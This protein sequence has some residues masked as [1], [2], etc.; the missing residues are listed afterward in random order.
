MILF[1]PVQNK[2]F[3]SLYHL[4]PLLAMSFHSTLSVTL[5]CLLLSY[6]SSFQV[7]VSITLLDCKFDPR[8][9][10]HAYTTLHCSALHYTTWMPPAYSILL[11][12]P[13]GFISRSCDI[14][15]QATSIPILGSLPMFF[16]FDAVQRGSRHLHLRVLDG[17]CYG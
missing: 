13:N 10:F 5:H 2:L 3:F 1:F 16:P 17:A 6:I 12:I 8:L 11:S 4:F 14:C 7:L 15:I 9:L